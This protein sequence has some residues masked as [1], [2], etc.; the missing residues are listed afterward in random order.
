MR[1][2]GMQCQNRT[3]GKN[4]TIDRDIRVSACGCLNSS[5]ELDSG[6]LGSHGE[7]VSAMLQ[8]LMSSKMEL[9]AGVTRE[10]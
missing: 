1:N 5:A 3:R 4:Y 6:N 2:T 9:S 10:V 7:V 8:G